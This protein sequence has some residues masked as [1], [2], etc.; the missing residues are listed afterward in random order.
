MPQ[1]SRAA[2]ARGASTKL[3]VLQAARELLVDEGPKAFSL[4]AVAARAGLSLSNLQ[5]H[6]RDHATL[7]RS[8]LDE[9]LQNGRRLVDA[10]LAKRSSPSDA[11]TG[12]SLVLGALLD[13]QRDERTMRLYLS[14]WSF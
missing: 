5:F 14:L 2:S 12:L 11:E 13:Q 4:R 7:L 9:E 3:R 1:Q 6:Y 10:A 8:L